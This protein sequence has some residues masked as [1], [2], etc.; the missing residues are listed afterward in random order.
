MAKQIEDLRSQRWFAPDNMRAFAHRQRT[1]QTGYKRSDFMGRPVIGIINTW[2][3]ISTCHTHLRERAQ[4]VKEGIIRA[5]GYPL[6]LPAM[7]LGEVMVKPTTMMYRNFLAMETEELLRSHPIDGAI[8]MGGCDKTTPGLLMG[9][10]SMNIPAIYIPA[11]ASLNGNFKGQKIGTGTHTRKFWDEKRAGNLS[12]EDWLEL[13][14]KMTR[15]V[16]TCNTMG[17]ASSLTSMA[18]VLGFCLPGSATIPAADS[19]HQR[20]C[21]LAGERITKMVFEDLTPKQLATRE[22]FENAIVTYVAL[23]GSTNGIIHLIAM[24]GRA[25]IDLPM[26]DFDRWAR[27]VPVIANLMPAGEYLMEDLF[28]AGGLPALLTR[29]KEHLHL[30]QLNV[31][32]RTLGENLEGVE[33]YNE[34]VVRPLDNPV[35]DRGTIGVITGN[36]CPDG[37]VCKPSAASPHLLKHRGKALVFENHHEMNAQIDDPALDVDENTVL[38]LKQAGPIG[39]P[40]MPEWGGLPIPKKLLQKGVRDMVRIS[41]ARMSGTHYGTCILHVAPE[42]YVGGP[43]AFVKTGDWIELDVE[44]RTLNLDI[45]D[46]EMAARKAAWTP[47]PPKFARGYGAM[48]SSHVTQA[49]AGCDFDFLQGDAV[50]DEPEIF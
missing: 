39:G 9:A 50:I 21:S 43:L 7:S 2:S 3:D 32:G 42:S 38:V 34:D 10:I 6:E 8:L 49:N 11:G 20:L 14:A 36:L 13:E 4:F 23:G 41:D 22:A 40:G 1:Q 16:G 17:T 45:S 15:S 27:K 18:E 48:F 24:A 37:A 28:Y 44:Q 30:D 19:A 26:A 31:N 46:E 47:P 29:L 12:D 5:G 33:I 35:N 25:G